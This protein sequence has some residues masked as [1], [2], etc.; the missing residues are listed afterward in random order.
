MKRNHSWTPSEC[1]VRSH[2]VL[3][4]N[5]SKSI[6]ENKTNINSRDSFQ[7]PC[8]KTD[9][10]MLWRNQRVALSPFKTIHAV[11]SRPQPTNEDEENNTDARWFLSRPSTYMAYKSAEKRTTSPVL[12]RP[13]PV[14]KEEESNI[15]AH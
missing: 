5:I 9:S 6:V 10:I 7:D 8:S 1:P 11:I 13:Q 3:C 14:R 2:Y 15:D 12:S 4:R